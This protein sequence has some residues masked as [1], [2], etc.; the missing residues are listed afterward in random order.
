MIK[1]NAICADD[2]LDFC[3][4]ATGPCSIGSTSPKML[5]YDYDTYDII[6]RAYRK[7]AVYR[8]LKLRGAIMINGVLDMLP[9]EEIHEKVCSLYKQFVM[10]SWRV[11]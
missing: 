9:G 10:A 11:S 2:N 6:V 8:D 1:F 7:S 3:L 4:S 5:Q